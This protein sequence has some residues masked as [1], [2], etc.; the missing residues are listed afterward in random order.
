MLQKKYFIMKQDTIFGLS[1]KA[2]ALISIRLVDGLGSGLLIILIPL[3][4]IEL[5]SNWFSFPEPVMIGLVVSLYGI[6]SSV[7]QPVF[8]L[9]SDHMGNRKGFIQIGYTIMGFTCL[10]FAFTTNYEQFFML[11][12]FQ[13]IG[14]A[15]TFA[16]STGMLASLTTKN[17][18]AKAIGLYKATRMLGLSLGPILG[19]FL[20]VKFNFRIAFLTGVAVYIVGFLLVQFFLDRDEGKHEKAFQ[21]KSLRNINYEKYISLITLTTAIMIVGSSF[22]MVSVLKS[23]LSNRLE[24]DV[25][26][27]SFAFSVF[28]LSRLVTQVPAGVIADRVER[29]KMII[30]GLFMLVPITIIL[31]YTRTTFE[32]TLLRVLQGM[33]S[34]FID[35]PSLAL[36][37][38]SAREGHEGSQMGFVNMG[39]GMGAA[40]GPLITGFLVTVSFQLPF[41][42]ISAG[43][44]LSG[45]LVLIFAPRGTEKISQ[46]L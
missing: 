12:F 3:Y 18:R 5:P 9:L 40:L 44:M 27:F 10:T 25:I 6:I 8:G 46:N 24:M 38:D 15:F 32:F 36:A 28:S 2:I 20:N 30:T 17:V 31:A 7:L 41:L 23:A 16:A 21:T 19:G 22:A 13:G 4:V 39:F 11:R 34:A 14:L 43:T 26:N 42:I 1:H 33:V 45:L 37:A 35:G 29:R